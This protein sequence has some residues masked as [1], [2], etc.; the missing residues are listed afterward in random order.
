VSPNAAV[1]A[2][3]RGRHL[4]ELHVLLALLLQGGVDRIGP[5]VHQFWGY[6]REMAESKYVQETY[7][8]PNYS[9]QSP[10][11]TDV[12]TIP[13]IVQVEEAEYFS[14]QG[15]SVDAAGLDV[16]DCLRETTERLRAAA[17][18]VRED[19][20]LSAYWRQRSQAT[21]ND[22]MSLGYIGAINALEVLL[23]ETERDEC[24]CCGLDRSP[25]PTRKLQELVETY[26]PEIGKRDRE[27][28]YKLRSSLVHGHQI[29]GLD[30]R[31]GFG[32]LVP[33]AEGERHTYDTALYASQVVAIRWLR[34]HT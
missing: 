13:E 15:I 6:D 30:L 8:V 12:S 1:M 10:E 16:P 31:R 3:R 19:F 27:S 22:S 4:W 9:L 24:P 20:L 17:E 26:A 18:N 2:D 21:Y 29:L 33:R 5:V 32:A 23:P 34:A 14:R 11:F 28:L 7:S 25:G